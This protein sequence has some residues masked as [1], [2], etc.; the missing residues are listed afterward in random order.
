MQRIFAEQLVPVILPLS[1]PKE[2]PV[3]AGLAASQILG[4][5][6]C[7][8]VLEFPPVAALGRRELVE[9]VAPTVQRYLAGAL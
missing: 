6:L 7:R 2:A 8:Y 5:A 1:S 4:V 3:R 9:W